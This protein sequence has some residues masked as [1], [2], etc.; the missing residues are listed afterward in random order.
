MG[1]S[2]SKS[3]IIDNIK[4]FDNNDF[5]QHNN[6][7]TELF[8]LKNQTFLARV[9]DIYDGDTI[10][11]IINIFNNYYKFKV[12]LAGIDTPEKTSHD[13]TIKNSSL[14]ARF[15]L[16]QL[17]ANSNNIDINN[18]DQHINQTIQQKDLRNILNSNLFF[19]NILCDNFDKY[20]RLLGWI[21]NHNSQV[22]NS[23][24]TFNQKLIDENLAYE[25]LGKT[26][27]TEDQQQHVLNI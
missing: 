3:D 15:R 6:D 4:E 12:R 21:Y 20:G 13:P 16:F 1:C 17:I 5:L 26:K 7:N 23:V 14:K 8:S 11:C 25:Y 19:V 18:I 24:Q 27:L 22:Y 10:T 9:V 2:L